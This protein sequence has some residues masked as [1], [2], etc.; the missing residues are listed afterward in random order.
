M[1][2]GDE[3]V[4]GIHAVAALLESEPE[5]ILEVYLAKGRDDA[6]LRALEEAARAAGIAVTRVNRATLDAKTAGGI[7][8]GAAARA[9]AAKL[10]GDAE[11]AEFLGGAKEPLLLILDGVTDV[12][13][14][15]AC[16]R[17][18]DGAGADALVVP[19]DRS[20]GLTSA[21]VK[22]A[23]GAAESVPVF[24]VANLAR[25]LKEL[26]ERFVRVVGAAGEAEKV[27]YRADLTGPLAL[28]MGA[29]DAGLR[30]LTRENCD[31]LVKL[32]MLGRVTS[33]NVSVAAGICL[34][35]ARRQRSYPG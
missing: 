34:Y 31:E 11:L 10:L 26:R 18:C 27:V 35:E 17:C 2:G 15:G 19:R 14:L 21:A 1:S 5:R 9:R 12:R 32:P 8:Q 28:V 33:L 3:Y 25:T 24:R 20:A 4:Y 23:C 29:E 30:R 7:H 13:N 6:R 16:L 22:A